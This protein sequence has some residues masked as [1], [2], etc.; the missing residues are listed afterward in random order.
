[1]YARDIWKKDEYRK[2]VCI[3]EGYDFLIFWE[4]DLK[5]KTSAEIKEILKNAIIKN[6][7]NQ[8]EVGR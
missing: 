7:V 5:K 2:R 6:T 8:Q 1:M 3:E 4:G